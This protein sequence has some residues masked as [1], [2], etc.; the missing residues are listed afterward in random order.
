MIILQKLWLLIKVS[1]PIFWF[2][3]PIVYLV[4]FVFSGGGLSNLSYI[5]YI[6]IIFLSFP[7][8]IF[9]YGINDVFDLESDLKNP[10]KGGLEGLRLHP[11]DHKLVIY[12]SIL[13]LLLFTLLL[14]I[15]F[16]LDRFLA[17]LTLSFF[18]YAYSAKPFRL[19]E[20]PPL[21]SFS[22]AILYFLAPFSLGF[23][24]N[25]SFLEIPLKVYLIA[26]GSSGVHA[27]TTT[28]DYKSDKEVGDK[29]FSVVYGPRLAASF[30]FLTTLLVLV[31]AD[32]QTLA[33]NIYL[34][35]SL[36]V[37]A[38]GIIIPYNTSLLKT[39]SKIIYGGFIISAIFF[40][41]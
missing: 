19:K 13:I 37:Y 22:N 5:N 28:L 39:G 40:L 14:L 27:Y 25:S 18:T 24:I 7:F 23:L 34:V 16:E 32:I 9:L 4:G 41:I 3:L 35:V 36:L 15:D 20:I 33:I 10:R 6:E 8:C 31:L 21:D 29:T 17:F 1:R 30:S 38:L 12:T 2:V 26:L 11:K